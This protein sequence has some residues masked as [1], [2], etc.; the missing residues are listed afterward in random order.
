M[1]G[2]G[3]YTFRLDA[4]EV[5]RF[6]DMAA[7]A[8]RHEHDLWDRAGIG[9]GA[10]VVDLGCGPGAISRLLADLVG[11][12]GSVIAVDA[13]PVACQRVRG[14]ADATATADAAPISVVCADAA[15]NGLGAGTADVVVLRNVLVHNGPRAGAILAAA[16]E[17]LVPGGHLL[18]A[19][20]DVE[21][22]DFGRAVDERAYED[23]WA[24][25]MRADGHD[26]ALGRDDHLPALLERH[27]WRVVAS[28]SWTDRL[29]VERS[30]AWAAADRIVS[31]G[32][33]TEAEVDT[34][35]RA[36]EARQARGPLACALTMNTVVATPTA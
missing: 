32:F 18:S 25:M 10:V 30:P 19:E 9:P 6:R 35:R 28:R 17:L 16:A 1:T 34:W 23:R 21:G 20:P 13:D 3:G 22:I 7:N 2:Q 15:D 12:R 31:R 36:L 29:Q 26:P 8:Q 11:P 4:A 27:G 14:M 33:A 5:A 24:R